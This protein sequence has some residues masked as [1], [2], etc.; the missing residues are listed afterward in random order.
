MVTK[1]ACR[2]QLL[3][4]SPGVS[5]LYHPAVS[6]SREFAAGRVVYPSYERSSGH[7]F[8]SPLVPQS[9]RHTGERYLATQ[10]G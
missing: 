4:G 7:P 8:E 1:S 3:E 2:Q 6:R 10:Q 5:D 9:V